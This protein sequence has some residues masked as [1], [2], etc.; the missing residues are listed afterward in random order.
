VDQTTSDFLGATKSM[1]VTPTTLKA[2]IRL[3]LA[4]HRLD[5]LMA[6]YKTHFKPPKLKAITVVMIW[7]ETHGNGPDSHGIQKL[8]TTK[9]KVVDSIIIPLLMFKYTIIVHTAPVFVLLWTCAMFQMDSESYSR[10]AEHEDACF[11][12]Q[13][14]CAN[15]LG[16]RA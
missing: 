12:P 3:N 7:L 8:L 9:A 4:A 5:S 10:P 6:R 15:V 14:D 1:E 13:F 2:E 16:L 11:S